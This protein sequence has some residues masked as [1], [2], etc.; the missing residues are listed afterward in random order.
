[1]SKQPDTTEGDA[2]EAAVAP[3]IKGDLPRGALT[4]EE[5]ERRLRGREKVSLSMPLAEAVRLER[6]NR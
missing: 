2:D 3:P 5:M 1:M 4:M 6:D